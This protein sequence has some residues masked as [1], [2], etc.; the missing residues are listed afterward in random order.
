MSSEEGYQRLHVLLSD[1]ALSILDR[2]QGSGD[3]KS[4]SRTIE[5]VIFA[6]EDLMSYVK[7]IMALVPKG[8][9]ITEEIVRNTTMMIALR[10]NKLG[11]WKLVEPDLTYS[12]DGPS[13]KRYY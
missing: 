9:E 2:I 1:D 12:E 3:F 5:E 10:L 4:R 11:L 7:N 6:M 13:I 8:E